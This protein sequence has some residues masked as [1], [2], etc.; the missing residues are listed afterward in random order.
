MFT[1][2]TFWGACTFD[3]P[4][5][6]FATMCVAKRV[7]MATKSFHLEPRMTGTYRQSGGTLE[8]GRATRRGGRLRRVR[9][10]PALCG[11]TDIFVERDGW[12]LFHA[13]IRFVKIESENR[14]ASFRTHFAALPKRIGLGIATS[15][16]KGRTIYVNRSKTG[17]PISC[18]TIIFTPLLSWVVL[19]RNCPV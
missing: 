1:G 19:R 15:E 7:R 12:R 3:A 4:V 9:T 5:R 11:R 6:L 14:L 10:S 13:S 16:R 8:T 2:D 17:Y 18:V